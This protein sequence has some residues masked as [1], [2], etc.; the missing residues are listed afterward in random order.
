MRTGPGI[1]SFRHQ[2]E[3]LGCHQGYRARA[4]AYIEKA[5]VRRSE[6]TSKKEMILS[7]AEDDSD[8][9]EES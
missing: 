2:S 9:R 4:C 1:R 6:R 7:I 3:A 8:V 5:A